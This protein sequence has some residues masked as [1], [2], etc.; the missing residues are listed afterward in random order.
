[1][2]RDIYFEEAYGRLYE[3][4][5]KNQLKVFEFECQWGRIRHVFIRREIPILVG[6]TK[7]YDIITPYGYGG[8]MIQFEEP[9]AREKLVSCFKD[10][11]Y[12]YCKDEHIVSEFV[13]FHPLFKNEEPFKEIY[14]V[15]AIRKTLGTNLSDYEDPVQEEF[16]KSC[17]K[18]IRQALRKGVTYEV[19]EKPENLQTF[20]EVYYDT[21]KRNEAESYYYFK[22]EYFEQCVRDLRE[23]MVL[24]KAIYE[25]KVIA[26]GIY[27]SYGDYIH[28][29]LS[30]T[31]KDY[32]YLSPAYVLRYGITRWGKEAGYKLIHHGGGRSNGEEDALYKFKKQFANHTAFDFCIGKKIWQP[33]IYEQLCQLKG[34]DLGSDFFPAYRSERD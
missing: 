11:F 7:L 2:E 20:M 8:P 24:V 21:M 3:D 33:E 9:G 6:N 26:A 17:R 29:H 28:V 25:E 1:M 18:S 23:H 10:A 12:K 31:L 4:N 27:F 34:A 16:S 32:L 22:E 5:E 30:G 15:H 19:V 13:R 14:E